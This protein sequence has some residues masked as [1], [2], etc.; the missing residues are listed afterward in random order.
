V[1]FGQPVHIAKDRNAA[2]TA[3][4]LSLGARDIVRARGSTADRDAVTASAVEALER[5][6]QAF[7]DL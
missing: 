4:R 6:D 3:L 7:R 1:R 2:V 5:A